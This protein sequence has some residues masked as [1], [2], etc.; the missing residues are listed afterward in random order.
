[1]EK[2]RYFGMTIEI[3]FMIKLQEVLGR[4]TRLLSLDTTRTA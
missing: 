2:Y 4:P 3:T 1:M